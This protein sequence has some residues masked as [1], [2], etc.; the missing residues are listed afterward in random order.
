LPI[1]ISYEYTVAG[2]F[3]L[4]GGNPFMGT[5][6]VFRGDF[7]QPYGGNSL[8]LTL[9]N[10]V[11]TNIGLP[12]TVDNFVINDFGFGAFAGFDGSTFK[13]STNQ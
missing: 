10:C 7:Y 6:P 9:Y 8:N 13:L 5:T 12:T 3:T 4:D 2:G 11:G 1:Q